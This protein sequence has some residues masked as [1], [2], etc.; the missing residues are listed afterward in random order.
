VLAL[1]EVGLDDLVRD[2]VINLAW[3]QVFE[4]VVGGP[5]L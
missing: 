3:R 2:Q 1:L 4:I 5:L